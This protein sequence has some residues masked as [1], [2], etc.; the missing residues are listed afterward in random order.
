MAQMNDK[1]TKLVSALSKSLSL[2]QVDV[3]DDVQCSADNSTIECDNDSV[4]EK[5]SKPIVQDPIVC[6]EAADQVAVS[7]SDDYI[8]FLLNFFMS[9][10][11]R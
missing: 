1:F 2:A 8:G 9:D 4:A 11:S 3:P 5:V 6:P 7:A 10:V